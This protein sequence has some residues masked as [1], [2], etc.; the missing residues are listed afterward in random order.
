MSQTREKTETLKATIL[1][2]TRPEW[3]HD[4]M[5]CI[6]AIETEETAREAR[7]EPA[8]RIARLS[9]LLDTI[10]SGVPPRVSAVRGKTD[11]YGHPL[12]AHGMAI[13]PVAGR[14]SYTPPPTVLADPYRHL[15]T[16]D[17]AN[18]GLPY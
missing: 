17:R 11:L 1:D 7:G 6:D 8:R 16:I 12:D 14:G 3:L 5:D 9:I 2:A 18:R 13:V 10:E 15:S 4:T